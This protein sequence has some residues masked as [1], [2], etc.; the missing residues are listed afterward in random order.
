MGEHFK[1]PRPISRP[2][3][4]WGSH[5]RK[6]RPHTPPFPLSLEGRHDDDLRKEYEYATVS[7]PMLQFKLACVGLPPHVFVA[8]F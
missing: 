7:P 2:G 6:E 8:Q 3:M 1:A 4:F 5:L